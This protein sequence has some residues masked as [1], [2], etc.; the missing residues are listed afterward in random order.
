M[1]QVALRCQPL[2]PNGLEHWVIVHEV[3]RVCTGTSSHRGMWLY[4][5]GGLQG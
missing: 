5:Y 2:A 1:R 3:E 4:A